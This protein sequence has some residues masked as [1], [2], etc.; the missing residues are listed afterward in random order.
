MR[1]GTKILAL[2]AGIVLAGVAI[3]SS[4]HHGL[5]RYSTN[6]AV[7]RIASGYPAYKT[8]VLSAIG[9]NLTKTNITVAA[10]DSS[11][12]IWWKPG[13]GRHGK[14]IRFAAFHVAAFR[15]WISGATNQDGPCTLYTF[16][17]G[18]EANV[19]SCKIYSGCADTLVYPGGGW[20]IGSNL[21]PVAETPWIPLN[22]D[23]ILVAPAETTYYFGVMAVGDTF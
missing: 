18:I 6:E 8:E 15:W 14:M 7:S 1:R 4:T 17:G 5:K 16:A 9:G 2:L 23:S 22:V 3:A 20:S 21:A 13:I 10:A 11:N 19:D 12:Y